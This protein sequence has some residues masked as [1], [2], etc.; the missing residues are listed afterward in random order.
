ML[1]GHVTHWAESILYF[2]PIVAMVG[3]FLW[4][5]VRGVRGTAVPGL[6]DDEELQEQSLPRM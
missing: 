4:A 5:R 1:F 6:A 3:A 2:M